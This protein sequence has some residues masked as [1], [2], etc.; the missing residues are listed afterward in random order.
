[1]LPILVLDIACP[2]LTYAYLTHRAAGISPALALVLSGVFPALGNVLSLIRSRTLD[3]IG[4]FVLVGIA[5]GAASALVSGD[6]KFV[7][8]R[9]SFVTAALGVI[10]LLSLLW[11]RPLL[12]YIGRDFTT[13]H[14]PVRVAEFNTL[15]DRPG[16]ERVFRI[17]TTVWGVGWVGEFVLKVLL[18]LNLS[19]PRML[20]VGPIL[21]NGVTIGLILWTLR[22]ARESRRR[23]EALR[24]AAAAPRSSA[25][26]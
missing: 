26:E 1:L 10:C 13:G 5:V 4:I 2:Y 7:L 20:V 8:I 21:S 18:V 25:P 11:S 3:I 14:D 16:A 22:Y 17:M 12:F 6:P 9:E 15:W 24:A 19:I 23:G